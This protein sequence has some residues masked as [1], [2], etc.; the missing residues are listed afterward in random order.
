MSIERSK[1]PAH[2]QCNNGP[3]QRTC[4]L[5]CAPR[6]LGSWRALSA[7]AERRAVVARTSDEKLEEVFGLGQILEAVL[8]EIAKRHAGQSRIA[9]RLV[10]RLREEDLSPVTGRADAGGSVHVE[11]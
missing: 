7:G 4:Q 6:V 11:P 10:H 8:A 1:L 9:E 3:L 2:A 5:S